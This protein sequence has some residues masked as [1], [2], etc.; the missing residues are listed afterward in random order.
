LSEND[1]QRALIESQKQAKLKKMKT[2]ENDFYL[3]LESSEEIDKT[4][5]R[6]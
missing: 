5:S 4:I 6:K 1:L 3:D 2:L